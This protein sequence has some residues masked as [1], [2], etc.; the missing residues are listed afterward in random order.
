MPHCLREQLPTNTPKGKAMIEGTWKLISGEQNGQEEPAEEAESSRLEIT[1]DQH[2]VTVGDSVMKGTHKL[3]PAQTPM[4]IDSTD[5]DG[6]FENMSLKGIFEVE[7]DVFT[8][9]FAAPDAQRPT[10][11]T[12]KDGKAA[13]MHVWKRLPGETV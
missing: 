13:M 6:P 2:S 4:T 11:G 9:C 8:V 5:T 3:D 7:G 1:G 12:T 10:E